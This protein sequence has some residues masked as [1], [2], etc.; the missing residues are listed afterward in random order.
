MVLMPTKPPLDDALR[1]ATAELVKWMEKD[2]GMNRFDAYELLSIVARIHLT[3]MVD[4][5][6]VV[7]TG[8]DKKYLP[9]KRRP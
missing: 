7:I 8:I 4:P 9:P 6:F 5:N 3:E 1:I 2:Y